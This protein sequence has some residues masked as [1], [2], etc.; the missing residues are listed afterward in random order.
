MYLDKEYEKKWITNIGTLL[1]LFFRI[2]N[3]KVSTARICNPASC[4]A[5]FRRIANPLRQSVIIRPEI[6]LVESSR[7]VA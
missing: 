2:Y 6:Y 1:V 7:R 4:F 3:P 5:F